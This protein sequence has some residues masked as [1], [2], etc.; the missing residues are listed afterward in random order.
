MTSEEE[1]NTVPEQGNTVVNNDFARAC[2][3]GG[4]D[5]RVIKVS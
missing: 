1:I 5:G 2:R 3:R 4:R